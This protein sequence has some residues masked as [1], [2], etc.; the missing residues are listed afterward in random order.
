MFNLDGQVLENPPNPFRRIRSH[1]SGHGDR[2]LQGE[3][4]S[5]DAR[6]STVEHFL[7]LAETLNDAP[8]TSALLSIE[9]SHVARNVSLFFF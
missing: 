4:V 5:L 6:V 1:D 9:S 8:V 2:C 3:A 7:K